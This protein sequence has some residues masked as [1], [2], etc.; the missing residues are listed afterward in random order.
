MVE[1]L[2]HLKIT[3]EIDTN[4]DTY[5][6]TFELGYDDTVEEIIEAMNEWIE[7]NLP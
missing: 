1:R 3:A 2:R 6:K 4:K 7:A 5:R